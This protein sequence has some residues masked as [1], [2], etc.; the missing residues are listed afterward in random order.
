MTIETLSEHSSL[1]VAVQTDAT[2][3]QAIGRFEVQ[4]R[5]DGLLDLLGVD[6]SP[7]V[8]VGDPVETA[9]SS[10]RPA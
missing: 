9:G 6:L 3:T 2:I 5:S 8:E 10:W 7:Q 4:E 1:R